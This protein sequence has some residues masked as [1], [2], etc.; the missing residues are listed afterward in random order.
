MLVCVCV[1]GQKRNIKCK[2]CVGVRVVVLV[3]V[4]VAG[5]KRNSTCKGCVSVRVVLV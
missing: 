5:Q 3:C 2:G 4:C 1:A